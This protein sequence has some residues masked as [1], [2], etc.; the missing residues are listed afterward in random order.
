MTSPWKMLTV[1]AAIAA[2]GGFTASVGAASPAEVKSCSSFVIS[3]SG[4]IG[5]R[6]YEVRRSRYL[7]C[8]KARQLLKA[9]YGLGPLEIVRVVQPEV[10]RPTYWVRGG[11]RCGNGA[12]GAACRN[13]LHP[14]LNSIDNYGYPVA[15]IASVR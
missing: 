5:F 9:A 6:A 10:G 3:D 1:L 2:F 13:A 15:V 11:W 8:T 7:T 14:G 12:G 4:P